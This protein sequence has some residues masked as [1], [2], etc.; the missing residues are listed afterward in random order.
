MP[1]KLYNWKRFW[2]PREGKLNLSDSGY[3]WDPDSEF[4]SIYNPDVVP[5][6]SISNVPCLALLGE[7]G[8]GKST[9]MQSQKESIDREVA[10]RGDASLWIDLR[11]YQTDVRL[12]QALFEVPAFKSW[13]NGNHRLHLFLDSL[14]EC[15]LRIDAVAALLI[16]EFGKY[17]LDRLSLRIACRTADWPNSLEEGLRRIWGSEVVKIYELAPLRR[18]DV[19][20]AAKSNGL[21]PASFLSEL[22]DKGVIPLAIKPVT[23][24][25]L[26]NMYI[27]AGQFPSRQT[28]LY[29]EGCRLLWAGGRGSG[30]HL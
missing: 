29:S 18:V 1:W 27:R 17:P 9:A 6:G 12:V 8:I 24:R 10:E 4:G 13:V 5:F 23:L 25:F 15:L 28:E 30:L 20:E 19:V 22:D 7:P 26:L 3:L 14:D 2:C 11:A 21:D 16:E